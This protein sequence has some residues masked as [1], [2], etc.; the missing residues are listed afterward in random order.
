[1]QNKKKKPIALSKWRIRRVTGAPRRLARRR[2]FGIHSP[3]AFDF[4][5]RVLAQPCGYYCYP[6]LG[7]AARRDGVSS[8]LLRLL[9]RLSLHFRPDSY[10]I[11]GEDCV[12][13][14]EAILS[15]APHASRNA[16][17]AR[18]VVVNG[19]GGG[20]LTFPPAEPD[21]DRVIVVLDPSANCDMLNRVWQQCDQ[22]MLFRGSK[23]AVIVCRQ[24]LPRQTFNVW[25]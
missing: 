24:G 12:G 17:H 20:D 7:S 3:F 16:S 23:V 5:R 4:V 22:A 21:K 10:R 18:F 15:G 19:G 8:R 1:M 14:H 11:V 2:G 25:I 13:F 6:H 9:F